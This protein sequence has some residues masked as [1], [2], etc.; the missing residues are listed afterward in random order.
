[1]VAVWV[2]QEGGKIARAVIGARAGGAVVAASGLQAL[3]VEF[4]DRGMVRC[5]ERNMGAGSGQSLMQIK[6][7]RRLALRPKA[8]AAVVAR[9]QDIAERRQ[10]GSVE[11]HASVEISDFQAEMVIHDDLQS[12]ARRET[13]G[14]GD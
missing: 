13:R 1:S 6:P 14:A 8:G 12:R 3:A 2:D 9:A 11:A 5:A 4:P 10:C 7:Q